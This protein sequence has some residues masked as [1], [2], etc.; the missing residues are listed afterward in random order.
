MWKVLEKYSNYSISENGDLKNNKTNKILKSTIHKNGYKHLSIK[1]LGRSGKCISLKLHREVAKYF[2]PNLD[3]KPQVNHID[4][5]KL[6]NHY[7]NLEWVTNQE[8]A[9]HAANID[10]LVIHKGQANIL[11][12]LKDVD[13]LFIRNNYD[14]YGPRKLGRMFGVSHVTIIN[15]NKR[16]TWNHI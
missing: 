10:L 5:D 13:I 15:I 4:G 2:V 14:L 1:P 8:N 16:K 3:N 7:T 9:Q 11:S 12:K 6:N